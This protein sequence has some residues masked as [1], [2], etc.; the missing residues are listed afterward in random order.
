MIGRIDSSKA[1]PN[2]GAENLNDPQRK[3][4]GFG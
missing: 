1:L 3:A 4:A 2:G